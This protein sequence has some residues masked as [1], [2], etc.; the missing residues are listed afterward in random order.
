MSVNPETLESMINREY[1][2][3]INPESTHLQIVVAAMRMAELIKQRLP[4]IVV[5]MEIKRG[6]RKEGAA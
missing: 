6:L 1:R 3:V 2:K 5:A 4:E